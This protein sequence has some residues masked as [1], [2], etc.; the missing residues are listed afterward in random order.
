MKTSGSNVRVVLAGNFD[1]REAW[2]VRDEISRV[3]VSMTVEIDFGRITELSDFALAT[4]AHGLAVVSP[5]PKVRTRG[6]WQHP[7]R[8][9][10]LAGVDPET[11]EPVEV[12]P[13]RPRRPLERA[14]AR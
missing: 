4:L 9:L 7:W 2:R 13:T 6:L 14:A 3:P 5:R 10:Q 12:K 1:V 11:F 8:L